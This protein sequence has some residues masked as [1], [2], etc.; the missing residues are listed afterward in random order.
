M[1]EKRRSR[2][3][4]YLGTGWLSHQGSRY[5]CR[6]EN[7]S[8]HGARVGLKDASVGPI[9]RGESCSLRLYQDADGQQYGDFRAQVVRFESAVA[10]LEFYEVEGTSKDVLEDIIRKEQYLYDGAHKIIDLAR[11]VAEFRGITLTDVHF[12][13][14]EL[15]PE[16]EIHTLRFFAGERTS[17]VHLHRMDIEEFYDKDGAVPASREIHKA[18]DRLHG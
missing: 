6:L 5:F 16:R 13:R 1:E 17:N 15:I 10:G 11:E 9:P 4:N 7:I 18:I 3:I 14:G 12:D 2:R 8:L